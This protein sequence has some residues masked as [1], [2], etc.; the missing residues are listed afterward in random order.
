[1][2]PGTFGHSLDDA[3]CPLQGPSCSQYD[4]RAFQK[5]KKSECHFINGTE[6]VRLVVRHI[7]NRQQFA[8][9]DSDVGIFVGDTPFGEFQARYWNSK[10]ETL[11]YLRA[12]VDRYCR[13][14]YR[15]STPFSVNCRAQPSV[16]PISPSAPQRVILLVPSSSQSGPG[17]LLCSVMD[18]YPARFQDGQE[19]P[20]HVVTT[21]VVPN[22]DWTYQV[23]V[24]L[25]IP[26]RRGVTYTCQVE[27]VSLEHPLSRHW[28]MPQDTVRSKILVGVGGF[29]LGFVFLVLGL[30]FY[31]W[32]KLLSQRWPQP[33]PVA[34]GPA[35]T[36][37]SIPTRTRTVEVMSLVIARA[38]ARPAPRYDACAAVPG[39][40]AAA[41]WFA[42][43]ERRHGRLAR[44]VG[45]GRQFQARPGRWHGLLALQVQAGG[46]GLAALRHR[47]V[48]AEAAAPPSAPCASCIYKLAPQSRRKPARPPGMAAG[49][50]R[51]F[52]SGTA[53]AP[54]SG[55]PS[56]APPRAPRGSGVQWQ[57]P[58]AAAG[59]PRSGHRLPFCRASAGPRPACGLRAEA[60]RLS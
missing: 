21:D 19:L 7:Y 10:Q 42:S 26:P 4:P 23:L 6:R 16:S 11:E 50:P 57:S 37:Q 44:V 52:S 25:E 14:N 60:Y 17:R 9:F 1:M 38:S 20:E 2:A 31:L 55:V 49:P 35:R 5:L 32:E 33:L 58:P 34:S 47:H 24:M 36:P 30:G 3:I 27:H 48:F 13:H 43:G 59:H 12:A 18:F 53:A 29:V 8:H 40:A 15:V 39:R 46:E 51:G 56:G 22:G 45:R 28:E 54:R 41:A